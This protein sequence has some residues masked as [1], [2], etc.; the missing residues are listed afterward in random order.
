MMFSFD[1]IYYV[2]DINVDSYSISNCML[3]MIMA[4]CTIM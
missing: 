2:L 3:W 1:E 4:I